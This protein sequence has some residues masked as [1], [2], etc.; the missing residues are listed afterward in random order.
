MMSRLAAFI[1]VAA[2]AFISG[3][4]WN[5]SPDVRSI[6]QEVSN[7]EQQNAKLEK[8]VFAMEKDYGKLDKEFRQLKPCKCKRAGDEAE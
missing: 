2:M 7:L 6:R 4:Q 5:V 3:C 8:R 1:A